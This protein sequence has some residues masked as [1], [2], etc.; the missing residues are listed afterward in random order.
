[1]KFCYLTFWNLSNGI[2][3]VRDGKVKQSPQLFSPSFFSFFLP[4]PRKIARSGWAH[5]H[6]DKVAIP[7]KGRYWAELLTHSE[8]CSHVWKIEAWK[9]DRNFW[10]V[11]I[12]KGPETWSTLIL[13]VPGWDLWKTRI[14]SQKLLGYSTWKTKGIISV[15][16]GQ[17]VTQRQNSF[18]MKAR[19]LSGMGL[20][21]LAWDGVAPVS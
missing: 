16:T 8:H 13:M 11:Q 9:D 3:R 10:G 19:R 18:I 21:S 5:V 6:P 7:D 12:K 15:N 20:R 4:V 17:K 1:M 2:T 14:K